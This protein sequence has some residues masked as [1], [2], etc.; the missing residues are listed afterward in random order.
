MDH[1]SALRLRVIHELYKN[2]ITISHELTRF[3]WTGVR[4]SYVITSFGYIIQ[5]SVVSLIFT[6]ETLP[7]IYRKEKALF[8]RLKTQLF[9]NFWENK[10]SRQNKCF[11]RHRMKY[12]P[13][14]YLQM[15]CRA[16]HDSSQVQLLDKLLL[17]GAFLMV[18]A[19]SNAYYRQLILFCYDPWF[20]IFREYVRILDFNCSS[21][22]WIGRTDTISSFT[23]ISNVLRHF[24]HSTSESLCAL[25]SINAPHTEQCT[26]HLIAPDPI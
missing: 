13:A 12:H 5:N 25:F 16:L 20:I 8:Y 2:L 14:L 19:K 4:S 15:F 17:S 11:H 6:T 3:F 22:M 10:K 18:P 23:N 24:L 21:R 1:L 9:F 26:C 7:S